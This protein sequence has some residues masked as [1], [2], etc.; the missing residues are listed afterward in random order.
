MS[1]VESL[2]RL[3]EI[4]SRLRAP[5]GCPWDREQTHESLRTHLIEEAYEVVESIERGDKAHLREELGDLLLQV[6]L[7]SQIASESSA[8][9]LDDVAHAIA[10]KLVRRHPHVFGGNQ[11]ATSEAVLKQWDQIKREEKGNEKSVLEGISSAL[12]SLMYAEKVQKRAARVGFDWA[13]ASDVIDKLEEELG[14]IRAAFVAGDRTH[15]ESEIGDLLFAAVNL[16]RKCGFDAELVL[17]K[18]VARFIQRFQQLE[19]IVAERRQILG[20]LTL[21]ELDAIWNDV[22]TRE[23]N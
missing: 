16:A 20:E 10:E 21:P 17:R 6:F 14:E 3:R 11:L 19:N 13:D 7:H 15:L 8:F 2:Q 1:D 4:V 12:P 5:D 23:R 22:K 18:A 9:T